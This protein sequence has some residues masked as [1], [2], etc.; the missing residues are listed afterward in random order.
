MFVKLLDVISGDSQGFQFFMYQ[1]GKNSVRGEV[2]DSDILELETC[3][4]YKQMSKR[5]LNPG[6]LVGYSFIIRGN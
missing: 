4:A 1:H 5:V 3:E 6:N 2:V